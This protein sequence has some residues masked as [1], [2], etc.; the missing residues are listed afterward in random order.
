MPRRF[1]VY[2]LS[3]TRRGVLYVGVT[4]DIVQ[5]IAQHRAKAVAG[6]TN[7]YGV[8]LLVY[9]EEHASIAEARAREGA[10]KRWRRDWKFEL[11]ESLNPEWRDLADDLMV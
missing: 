7:R 6:F 8:M 1:H 3:N 2:I 5:R 10:L 9:L 4:S 11:I